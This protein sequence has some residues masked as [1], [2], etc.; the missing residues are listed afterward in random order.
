M[1]GN[2]EGVLGIRFRSILGLR[3][4]DCPSSPTGKSE[5][6]DAAESSPLQ[7]I[8]RRTAPQAFRSEG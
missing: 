3:W 4:R 8:R 6:P 2:G 7:L 1:H 5:S